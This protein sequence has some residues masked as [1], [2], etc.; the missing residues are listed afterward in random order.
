MEI[1]ELLNG[2]DCTCGRHHSCAIDFIAI[3]GADHRFRNELAMDQAIKHILEF[4]AF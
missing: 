4:F 3:E 1:K 2:V